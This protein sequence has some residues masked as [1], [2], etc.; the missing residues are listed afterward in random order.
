MT[1]FSAMWSFV[2]ESFLNNVDLGFRFFDMSAAFGKVSGG[3][4]LIFCSC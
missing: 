3:V 2:L 1:V 4:E